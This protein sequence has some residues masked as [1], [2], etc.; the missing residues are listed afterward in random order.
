MSPFL[1]RVLEAAVF[2]FTYFHPCQKVGKEV[3]KNLSKNVVIKH[4]D[5]VVSTSNSYVVGLRF[6]Y[7]P[8]NWLSCLKFF[9]VCHSTSEQMPE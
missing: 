4:C 1:G 9:M 7:C 2:T 8:I 5:L 3:T 6:K